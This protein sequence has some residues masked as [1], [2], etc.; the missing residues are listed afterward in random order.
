[1]EIKRFGES[2]IINLDGKRISLFWSK[3]LNFGENFIRRFCERITSK[4][5]AYLDETIKMINANIKNKAKPTAE[6]HEQM[7]KCFAMCNH[8]IHWQVYA[9]LK[10]LSTSEFE[11][12]VNACYPL[13]FKSAKSQL[14][15]TYITRYNGCE[16]EL[17]RKINYAES[18]SDWIITRQIV[19]RFMANDI[20]EL[21]KFAICETGDKIIREVITLTTKTPLDFNSFFI[22]LFKASPFYNNLNNRKIEDNT[23]RDFIKKIKNIHMEICNFTALKEANIQKVLEGF[24][25][26]ETD[27]TVI[28]EYLDDLWLTIKQDINLLNDV[29]EINR[30]G[31]LNQLVEG[32]FLAMPRYNLLGETKPYMKSDEERRAIVLDFFHKW[33]ANMPDDLAIM[34][35]EQELKDAIDKQKKEM[36]DKADLEYVGKTQDQINKEREE[37]GGISLEI[38][39]EDGTVLV[40]TPLG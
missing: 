18:L 13:T 24:N 22:Q 19:A 3:K 28:I 15:K 9:Y 10:H 25:D 1:M 36:V 23:R 17:E 31:D 34:K 37:D 5:L 12:F 21:L 40:D 33:D 30:V 27:P 39:S 29:K 2:F 6:N 11:D 38:K 32:L 35:E 8:I 16:C 4:E 7:I 14:N 26:D 20:T